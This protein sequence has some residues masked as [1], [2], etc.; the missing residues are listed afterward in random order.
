MKLKEYRLK[1]TFTY[2]FIIASVFIVL[3]LSLS[4]QNSEENKD[5]IKVGLVLSGGGAKGLAHIGALKVL[6]EAGVRID[7]IGG[8]SMGA[9]IGGL[10]ASGYSAAQLDSIFE[11]TK[12]NTLIQDELPRS[13]K[14][15]YEKDDAEKYALTLPFDGFKIGFPSGLSKGQ[16][17]YNY[18]NRLTT[19]LGDL[20]DF[21]K[22]QTPFF[23]V[24]TDIETGKQVIIDNG[25]LPLAISA[26][27]AI[28]SLFTPVEING[29]LLTDGGVSN[30]YPIEELRRR[31]VDVVIGVNVQ[32]S[33]VDRKDLGSA[34]EILTQVNNFRTIQDMEGKRELTDIYIRPDITKFSVLSF[35]QG[36]EIISNGE[37][38][39]RTKM[40][41]LL[42]LAAR[43]KAKP[44]K[45]LE[46]QPTETLRI[47]AL[48]IIGNNNYP[49]SYIQGK[50]KI[51]TDRPMSYEEFNYGLNNLS[52]TGNFERVN[53]QLNP[54]PDGSYDLVINVLESE[55]RMLLRLGVHYDD[56]YRTAGLINVT[57]KCNLFK[58]DIASIDFIVG[59]NVR[60][61]FEY[62][63]DQGRYWSVGARSRYNN[64][65]KNVAFSL[66]TEN[67]SIP[68]F[69]VNSI[70]I[71]YK[72]FTSQIYIQTLFRQR[73]SLGFGIEHKYLK[74]SSETIGLDQNTQLQGTTFENSHLYSG[75][76]YLKLDTYDNKYFPSNG[77]L[78][79]GTFNLYAFSSDF[80]NDFDEFS[81]ARGKIGYVFSP[82]D[83]FAISLSSEA[84]FKIGRTENTSLNFLLGGY[85][86]KPINNII[87]FYGYDFISLSADSYI[88]GMLE[89]D[90]EVFRKNHIIASANFA[91]VEDDLFDSG[92]WLSTPDFTGYALGYGMETII[93]PVEVKWTYSP[94]VEESQFFFVV[95]FWF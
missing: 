16:N 6:E 58:N 47:R 30:N 71:N 45:K 18:M 88:K 14:T 84:G 39:S 92:N 54:N 68:N 11:K 21:S 4:A 36:K 74:I 22:L 78:F 69:D 32:D 24:A 83:K 27:G 60:Y 12:F 8:T 17:V 72:D 35:D 93:G 85:G 55:E 82:I 34:F 43:Q 31:G 51:R 3:A 77:F 23:C 42:E 10:Y 48:K 90:Y 46:V 65:E 53:H 63:V 2:K 37:K 70:E 29:Q 9:I 86:N 59:D 57:R 25:S 64:F 20:K 40:E 38:A 44:R 81:I 28:P 1:I 13:A 7:Y 26:S 80:N 94:E 76:G 52:A 91:N 89:L 62:Y 15:F 87:P 61:N 49:R 79:D 19:H 56:L 33:L 95:G 5:D 67:A 50:L 41:T 66:V 75:Y 73:Y